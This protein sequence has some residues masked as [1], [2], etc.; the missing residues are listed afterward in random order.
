M[1]LKTKILTIKEGREKMRKL[2]YVAALMLLS[3]VGCMQES[4]ITEPV[5]GIEKCQGKTIIM[6]PAKAIFCTEN[7]F[8]SIQQINGA[9]GGEG[10]YDQARSLPPP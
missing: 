8:T 10:A 5:N 1:K 2:S 6:L 4:N 3:L 9:S 7:V